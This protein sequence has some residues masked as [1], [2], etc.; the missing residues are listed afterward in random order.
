M[1]SNIRDYLDA[2]VM[3][4]NTPAFIPPDPIS[5]PHL[6][7]KPQDIEISAFWT[8]MLSWGQRK[9]ILNKAKLLFSLMDFAP[10]DF[11]VN[12]QENDR[13]RFLSFTHR[14]FQPIDT[15]HFLD[16]FQQYYR[17]YT[18]LEHAFSRFMSADTP[19]VEAALIGF[20]TLFFSQKHSPDRTRKHVP[21]PSRGSTCKRLN[22][23]LR[24]MVRQDQNGVDF[25]LWKNITPAQ[26]LIPLDVHVERTARRIGLISGTKVDWKTVLE[27]TQL[28]RT[29]DQNDP[30][31]YDYALF[32]LGVLDPKEIL[33][34]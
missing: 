14:T 32:G 33:H 29:F 26:L 15:F 12:H 5:I 4:F 31:K 10:H 2:Q 34:F 28:L 13:K 27:L 24:W 21:T 23:F 7:S 25:G 3:R 9:T 18:T 6:F 19:H 30:V 11:I 22:M 17:E 8:S 16:F 1:H 20:N